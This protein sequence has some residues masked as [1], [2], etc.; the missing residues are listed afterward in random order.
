MDNLYG[1]Y[2]IT[3]AEVIKRPIE[4]NKWLEIYEVEL[5]GDNNHHLSFGLVLKNM[6][7]GENSDQK[8][9]L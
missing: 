3:R 9:I 4:D 2:L 5:L 1:Q 8:E 6:S 7:G